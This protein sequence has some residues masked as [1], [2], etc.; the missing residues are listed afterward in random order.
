MKNK[1]KI[2][3]TGVNSLVGC[4]LWKDLLS[5]FDLYGTYH[6]KKPVFTRSP[7][8]Y[9]LDI[10]KKQETQDLILKLKPH[11]IIHLASFSMIDEC[12]KYP[13]LAWNI[14]VRG[15]QNLTHTLK[16]RKIHFIFFSSN[17]VFPGTNLI[18]TESAL[19]NP[20]NVYGQTKFQAEKLIQNSL[21]N[22]TVVRSTTI[23]G[24][25]PP[26]SRTNDVTYYLPRLQ[27]HD[28]LYLVNDRF[29]NPIYAE[30]VVQ[31]VS[32]IIQKSYQG[33]IHLAGKTQET[34]Y[35]M[36]Q[37]IIKGYRISYPPELVAVNSSYFPN[38]AGR[39][40]LACLDTQKMQQILKVKP[41]S[42]ETGLRL[43][44]AEKDI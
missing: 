40:K 39:P 21:N 25:N 31:A 5:N 2:L 41:L 14:N 35:T 18:Y 33:I 34:R 10:T 8:L 9:R 4:Y 17:A 44:K 26:G 27:D 36:V 29:F 13:D 7:Q 30:Q 43:M 24:W 22:W 11:V 23:Y 6:S 12:E 28:K 15:T 16:S 37:K 19:P 38:L 1:I 20:L 3:I 32:A 42:M